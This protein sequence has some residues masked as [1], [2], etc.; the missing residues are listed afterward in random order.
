[1]NIYRKIAAVTVFGLM[2]ATVATGTQA[3]ENKPPETK[4]KASDRT[5]APAQRDQREQREQRDHTAAPS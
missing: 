5:G 2:L 3:Q 1:M 4:R